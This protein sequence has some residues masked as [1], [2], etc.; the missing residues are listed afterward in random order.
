MGRL[1][2]EGRRGED[3]TVRTWH[4]EGVGSSGCGPS[5]GGWTSLRGGGSVAK[6]LVRSLPI[7]MV[8]IYVY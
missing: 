4:G 6:C 5:L 8:I 1:T 3:E 2:G 7:Y